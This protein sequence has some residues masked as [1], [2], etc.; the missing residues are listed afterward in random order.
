VSLRDRI[1]KAR[2]IEPKFDDCLACVNFARACCRR[3]DN[4]ELFEPETDDEEPSERELMR[5]YRDM[6]N[7]E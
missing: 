1:R 4:G 6:H 7:D 2:L 5:I 3:C